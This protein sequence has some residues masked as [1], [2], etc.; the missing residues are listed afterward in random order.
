M[1]KERILPNICVNLFRPLRID[2]ILVRFQS[3]FRWTNWLGWQQ[4]LVLFSLGFAVILIEIRNHVHM[5]QEHQSGQILWTDPEL[6][7]EIVIFGFVL[8][9]LA[10]VFLEYTGRTAIER[11]EMAKALELRRALIAQMYESQNWH[12]LAEI[13]VTT[14]LN[15]VSADRTWLLA[16]RSGEE[17][18][19][20]IAYWE[21]PGSKLR[22]LHPPVN[23]SICERCAETRSNKGTKFYSCDHMVTEN[24]IS[25]YT[26]YC[27]WLSSEDTGKTTLLID[28]PIDH[29]LSK[30]QIKVLDDLG[31]E[32]SLAIVNANLHYEKQRQVDHVLNERQRIARNL[33]DVLGQNISYLRLKLEQLNSDLSDPSGIDLQNDLSQ[34]LRVADEAYEQVRDTLEELRTQEHKDL[35]KSIQLYASQTGKRAGFSVRV[36]TSGQQRTLSARSSRQLMYILREALNNVEK[37]ARAQNVDIHVLWCDDEFKLKVY[38]D[39]VGFNLAE[40]NAEERY[41]MA[42]M[43]ERSRAIN[44]NLSIKSSPGK[45]TELILCIPLSGNA[46]P[47]AIRQ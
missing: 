19:D 24:N 3:R 44:A 18:F 34:M 8:P 20:Q 33:H 30:G 32:M 39:G 43:V 15:V 9:I 46:S 37:H 14:P 29:P 41:G 16:Q 21:R 4:W 25:A 38:D 5:W 27:R 22:L 47:G 35:G 45:G 31:D 42:I 17:E 2:S 11:D 36:H 1:K 23:P 7:W 40:V 28:V 26:R 12:E 10:G 6:L 13:I